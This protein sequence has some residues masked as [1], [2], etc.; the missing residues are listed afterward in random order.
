M[1]PLLI[2]YLILCLIAIADAWR[3]VGMGGVLVRAALAWA[4][5]RDLVKV[6]LGVF[7]DNERAIAV[8]ERAGFVREGLRRRQYRVDDELRDELLMAWF[9]TPAT[10]GES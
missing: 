1:N 4:T 6:Q 9:P 2:A 5:Q 3:D 7:P 8:Y 10:E